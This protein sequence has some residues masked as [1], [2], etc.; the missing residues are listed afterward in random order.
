MVVKLF[1]HQ[2]LHRFVY[3]YIC[4]FSSHPHDWQRQQLL[5]SRRHMQTENNIYRIYHA[6]TISH[7]VVPATFLSLISDATRCMCSNNVCQHNCCCCICSWSWS[8]SWSCCCCCCNRNP[9]GIYAN[10]RQA[11]RWQYVTCHLADTHTAHTR[12][13]R[14]R[15]MDR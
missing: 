3:I 9:I 6:Y 14:H 11:M 10:D 7:F 1:L 15:S 4:I 2:N 8:C 13:T 5:I 12:Y